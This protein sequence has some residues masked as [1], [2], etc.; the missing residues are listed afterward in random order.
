MLIKRSFLVFACMISLNSGAQNMHHEI[1]AKVDI[2]NQTIHVVDQVH[3]KEDYFK[4]NEIFSFY[5][6]SAF[7]ISSQEF[8]FTE[9][10]LKEVEDNEGSKKYMVKL[11]RG[12]KGDHTMTLKFEGKVDQEIKDDVESQARG[13]S[14]TSGVIS[15]EGIYMAGAT[16]WIPTFEKELFSYNLEVDI[17]KEWSVV[18][19][20]ERTK[21]EEKE[22]RRIIKYSCPN[23]MD[24]VYLIAAKFTEYN[25]ETDHVLVQAFLRTP[26]EEL[27]N[28]Y[29]K[30]TIDYL[31][32]FE[33]L[34]GE[35][36]FTKFALVENFWET[37]YGMP[38][39]TLLGEKIIRF[40]FI[41]HSSY[42]HE[43]LHNWWG[44]SVYIDYEGGNW[45]EGLTAYMA[46]HLIKEQQG[47][48]A[49][50]RR[51]ALEKFTNYVNDENDF[52]FNEFISRSGPSSAAIGY[53]KV[54]MFN[55]ML[56]YKVGDEKFLK[57]YAK[58]YAE[59]KFKYA[60]FDD[61]RIA[62]EAISRID[63]KPFF[64]Q[65]SSRKGAPAI[66]IAEVKVEKAEQYEMT[67]TLKQ[68]QAEDVFILDLP[69]A[70][71]EE[72]NNEVDFRSLPMNQREQT[73][74]MKFDNRPLR[75]DID[76]QTNVFRRLDV[77]EIP[78]ILS[79]L[80]GSTEGSIVL[81]KSSPLI[82]AYNE[83]AENWKAVQEAQDKKLTIL[84]DS[85]MEKLPSG[86]CWIIGNDNKFAKN[87]IKDLYGEYLSDE[88]MTK[89]DSMYNNGSLVY[90][91]LNA[92]NDNRITGFLSSTNADAIAALT[93][94]LPHYGKYS[95]LGFEGA[96][97]TNKLK[98]EFPALNS[99]LSYIIEYE[100]KPVIT[101]KL[102]PRKA[103]GE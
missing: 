60:S 37:G 26:D 44:N 32:L 49:K 5:L 24:E 81:P 31:E 1:E 38:S 100:D 63:L 17:D 8:S 87:Y 10:K 23:P 73:Y 89:V 97:A 53:G 46:D 51:E 90:T 33:G 67:F 98:G 47:L 64:K 40:P 16:V 84:F 71:Y 28:R 54:M 103:L 74:I 3:I 70:V 61:I 83:L 75:I 99:P 52:P 72:N 69:I 48:G 65:W 18:S 9:N 62:F 68:T 21:F 42:P 15:E 77:Q 13:Y 36:P 11:K 91:F 55:D 35:Y 94:K 93:R 92:E 22:N 79:Q 50:Y 96:E 82:D 30:I 41:L 102:E 34:I 76:P 4:N 58:F 12:V 14:S 43:L 85:D 66:E 7:T 2:S 101:S 95:F 80:F 57:A 20:G 6:N 45:C 86:P 78:P 29:L 39:F 19:Q 27:A 25:E 88:T 56:R 59:N